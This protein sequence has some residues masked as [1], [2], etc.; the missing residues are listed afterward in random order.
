[1]NTMMFYDVTSVYFETSLSDEEK[2]LFNHDAEL[3][4][5]AFKLITDYCNE[6]NCMFTLLKISEVISCC[7][8]S[9]PI[10]IQTHGIQ[11][12]TKRYTYEHENISDSLSGAKVLA[13]RIGDE[14]LLYHTNNYLTGTRLQNRKKKSCSVTEGILANN[15]IMKVA[16]LKPLLKVNS[17]HSLNNIFSR[18]CHQICTSSILYYTT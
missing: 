15:N 7:F 12:Q 18:K 14:I 16:G 4:S 5:E 13:S 11:T 9:L 2:Q 1:M 6:H 17:Y 8:I 10:Y 3:K